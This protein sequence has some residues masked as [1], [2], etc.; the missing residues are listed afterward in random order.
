MLTAD[1]VG[2]GR[3]VV[4]LHGAFS[5]RRVFGYQLV[6]MGGSVRVAAADLPGFGR[7]PWDR[8]QPWHERAV[9]GVVELIRQIEDPVSAAGPLVVGW[10]EAAAVACDA[11]LQCTG[12]QLV[13]VCAGVKPDDVGA[14][15]MRQ[16][17]TDHP[18]YARSRIRAS[19]SVRTSPETEEWLVAMATG[20]SLDA[21][22]AACDDALDPTVVPPG[23]TTITGELD[24]LLAPP[25]RLRASR[26]LSMQCGHT[27]QVE[28]ADQF[29]SNLLQL[30]GELS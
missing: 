8:A 29:T 4:L 22:V 13:L 26:D 17:A 19:T 23:T 15:A 27:P 24:R 2:S 11:V 1:V 25:E 6:G 7:S 16:L 10:S 3:V 5:D 12:A 18:R 30:E 21:Q 14:H 20:S 28:L 9:E